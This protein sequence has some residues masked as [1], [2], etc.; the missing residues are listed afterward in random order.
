MY[1]GQSKLRG[2]YSVCFCFLAELVKET[3]FYCFTVIF[4]SFSMPSKVIILMQ[5]MFLGI[6][7]RI[8]DPSFSEVILTLS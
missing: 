6:D 8:L 1:T 7:I 2:H 4:L 3:L 5:F